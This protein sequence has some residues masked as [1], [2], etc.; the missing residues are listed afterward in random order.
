ME[1]MRVQSDRLEKLTMMNILA[2]TVNTTP[3]RYVRSTSNRP[4]RMI[5]AEFT[6]NP[7][8]AHDFV[9]MSNASDKIARFVNPYN[10]VFTAETIEVNEKTR[11]YANEELN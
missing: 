2:I 10:R 4:D 5:M 1:G 11:E 8:E 7:D 9:T 6:S 3:K